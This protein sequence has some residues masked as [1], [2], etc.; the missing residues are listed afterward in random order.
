MRQCT[1]IRQRDRSSM[2]VLYSLL[3]R[4]D[5]RDDP[6]AVEQATG[7]VQQRPALEFDIAPTLGVQDLS[8][9]FDDD[10]RQVGHERELLQER[11]LGVGSA[12]IVEHAGAEDPLSHLTPYS[13]V[14]DATPLPPVPQRM[15]G[16]LI[17][18]AASLVPM[19]LHWR[20]S[21]YRLSGMKI[22]PGAVIDR[23]LQVTRPD[24]ITIGA[25][26]AIA[27]AVSLLGEVT[28][29]NSRLATVFDVEKRAEIVIGDDAWI[30]AKATIL[31][32]VR[33]G[34]MATVSANTLVTTNVPDFAVVAGVPGRVFL[35]R[36][37]PDAEGDSTES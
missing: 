8:G 4:D 2:V 28:P 24:Q 18:Y 35:V 32:G 30:G 16:K 5:E 9:H 22:G 33:I 10:V 3:D 14:R 34:R 21:C 23:N 1:L 6:H 12:R 13:F 29:V 7:A 37:D 19:P 15:I 31:P 25:R 17:R 20:A 36:E 27:N 26:V 11:R